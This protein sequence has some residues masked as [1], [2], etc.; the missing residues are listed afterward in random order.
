[1]KSAKG[2]EKLLN[3]RKNRI[4]KAIIEEYIETAEPVGST[5]VMEKYNLDYSSATIRNDMMELEREIF[6][7][8]PHTSAR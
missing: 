2:G 5:T 4:L 8:K 1:M 6:L 3:N 7:E